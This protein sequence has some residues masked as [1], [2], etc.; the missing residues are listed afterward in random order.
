VASI[1]VVWKEWSFGLN[2]LPSLVQL[3]DERK[4]FPGTNWRK[5]AGRKRF[6]K[7]KQVAEYAKLSFA[8]ENNLT[9]P[10]HTADVLGKRY[11]SPI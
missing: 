2:N 5:G 1:P 6:F 7:R 8:K 10:A 11:S 9:S 3:K 4:L